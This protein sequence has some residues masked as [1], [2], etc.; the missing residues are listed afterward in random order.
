MLI[1]LAAPHGI[2]VSFN[3]MTNPDFAPPRPTT[4]GSSQRLLPLIDT[5]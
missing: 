1:S 5:E 2:T 3:G 4:A